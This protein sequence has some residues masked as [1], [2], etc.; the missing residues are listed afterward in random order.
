[1]STSSKNKGEAED[2]VRVSTSGVGPGA[3]THSETS[4]GIS[5]LLS[6]ACR[7]GVGEE[8]WNLRRVTHG[9]YEYFLFEN[10]LGNLER[11]AAAQE[12]AGVTESGRVQLKSW[13]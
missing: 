12:R 5:P 2:R 9:N 13:L 10:P 3:C 11:D 4:T 8:S 1:M 7:L 6:K